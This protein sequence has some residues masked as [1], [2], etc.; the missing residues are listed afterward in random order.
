[1]VIKSLKVFAKRINQEKETQSSHCGAVEMNPTGNQEVAGS[2]PA[3]AQ[4]V[5]DPALP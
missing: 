2:I 4:W 3:L 1:M 5:D